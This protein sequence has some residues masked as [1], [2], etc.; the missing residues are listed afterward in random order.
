VL[1]ALWARYTFCLMKLLQAAKRIT[2]ILAAVL[3]P[4]DAGSS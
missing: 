3:L 2:I 4:Q 1:S